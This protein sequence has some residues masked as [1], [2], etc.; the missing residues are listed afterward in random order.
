MSSAP[1]S[2]TPPSDA[3][4]SDASAARGKKPLVG[5]LGGIASGKSLV[6]GQ[7]AAL[8]ARVVSADALAHEVLEYDEVKQMARERWG[9]VVIG[10]GGRVDRAA[11]ARIVFAPTAEAARERKVLESWTHPEV[12]R[13]IRERVEALVH[14]PS[15]AAVVLDVPLM[16]E[17]G[18]NRFCD[19]MLFVDAPR[20]ARLARAVARGWSEED[21]DRREAAQPPLAEKRAAADFVIDNSTTPQ[22]TA[23]QVERFWRTLA[24]RPGANN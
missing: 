14:D 7:L 24:S 5:I 15:V 12:G 19:R 13:L 8:G 11:V 9:D 18:W 10:P 16:L 23:A 22:A 3:P 17:S 4:V 6:A 2:E 21:F 20:E 1:V